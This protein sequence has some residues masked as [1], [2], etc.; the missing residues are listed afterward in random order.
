[1]E[2]FRHISPDPLGGKGI[3]AAVWSDQLVAV[4]QIG[5]VTHVATT[6]GN[7]YLDA[8]PAINVERSM[9]AMW[10]SQ[11]LAPAEDLKVGRGCGFLRLRLFP[12]LLQLLAEVCMP[13]ME[14]SPI[15]EKRKA[16][17]KQSLRPQLQTRVWTRTIWKHYLDWVVDRGG[18][19]GNRPTVSNEPN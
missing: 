8:G 18:L 19:C 14:E 16:E 6:R 13:I 5:T 11:P 10:I 1:M 15:Q 9:I 2:L 3:G 7:K 4:E 17:N 12:H